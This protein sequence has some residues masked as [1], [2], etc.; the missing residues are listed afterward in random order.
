MVVHR[1]FTP[2]V[3]AFAFGGVGCFVLFLSASSFGLCLFFVVALAL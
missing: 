3:D 1:A 2:D